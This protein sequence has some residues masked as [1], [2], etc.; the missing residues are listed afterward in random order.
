MPK[1]I[2]SAIDREL[3]LGKIKFKTEISF[4]FNV[5]FLLSDFTTAPLKHPLRNSVNI[6]KVAKTVKDFLQGTK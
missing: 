3:V 2:E 1:N 5:T 6:L 4:H